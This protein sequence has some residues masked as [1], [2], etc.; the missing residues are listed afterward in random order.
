MNKPNNCCARCSTPIEVKH[1]DTCFDCSTAIMLGVATVEDRPRSV[2]TRFN[3]VQKHL[4]AI[5]ELLDSIQAEPY[6]PSY[7]QSGL[8]FMQDKVDNLQSNVH[9]MAM[10]LSRLG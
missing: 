8:A 4:K 1:A 5:H 10:Y 3:E 2:A 9:S 6:I 7:R